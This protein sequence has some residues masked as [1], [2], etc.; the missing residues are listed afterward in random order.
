MIKNKNIYVW[1]EMKHLISNVKYLVSNDVK[2]LVSSDRKM[3][4]IK[5]TEIFLWKNI[6]SLEVLI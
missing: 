2:Y 1:I 6:A 5:L 3:N 4:M